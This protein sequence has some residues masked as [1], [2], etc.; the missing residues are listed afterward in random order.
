MTENVRLLRREDI[1]N[2]RTQEIIQMMN[3]MLKEE[4][5]RVENERRA[6]QKN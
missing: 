6:T 5:E 2:E 4:I 1:P 3:E